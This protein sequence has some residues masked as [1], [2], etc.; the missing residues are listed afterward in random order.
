MT[1]KK[2]LYQCVDMSYP[3]SDH[4][5]LLINAE[6]PLSDLHACASE[7]LEAVLKYLDLMA[8][9]SLPDHS[10]HDISTI[11]MIARILVQD[12]RDVFR[13]IGQRAIES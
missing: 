13:V 1:N 9:T 2:S 10:E 5:V 6:A 3:A 4:P 11:T 7:R 12:V 8:C